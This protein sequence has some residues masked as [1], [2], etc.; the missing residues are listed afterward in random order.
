MVASVGDR[1]RGRS[2]QWRKKKEFFTFF[3]AR[4]FPSGRD[5]RRNLLERERERERFN[6][7]GVLEWREFAVKLCWVKKEF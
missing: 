7:G 2:S 3:A 4:L 1:C 5:P 6:V